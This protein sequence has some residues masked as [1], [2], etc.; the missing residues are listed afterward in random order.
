M[1]QECGTAIYPGAQHSQPFIGRIPR[2]H[3]DVVQL[4]AQEVFNHTFVAIFHLNEIGQH[5]G[6]RK[7]VLLA[8]GLKQ[9]LYRFSGIAV[10]GNQGFQR[11]SFSQ[12]AGVLATQTVEP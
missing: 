8:A 11:R 4:I 7:T 3:Y 9:S 5:T 1:Y 2:L 12:G 6:S 10:L